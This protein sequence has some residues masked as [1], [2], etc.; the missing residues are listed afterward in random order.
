MKL[1]FIRHAEAGEKTATDDAIRDLTEKGRISFRKT[2]AWFARKKFPVDLIL[3]SPLIR[4]VQTAD[5]LAEAIAFKGP[6][7]VETELAPGFSR[8]SLTRLLERHATASEIVLVGHQPDFGYTVANL[9][10]L[11]V[12]LPLKKGE[13]ITVKLKT[14]ENITT[15][16]FC[17]R[18]VQ[19]E[20]R[21]KT[22]VPLTR[23]ESL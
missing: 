23:R 14:S 22:L 5:I 21:I 20:R 6:L 2:A 16:K 13:I 19:G 10:S 15:A 9:L 17:W 12:P 11:E 18:R 8:E 3:T 4:A 7:Q 1:Y